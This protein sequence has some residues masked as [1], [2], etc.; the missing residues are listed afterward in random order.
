MNW[1]TCNKLKVEIGH[2]Y[3]TIQTK[4]YW[5]LKDHFEGAFDQLQQTINRY[6]EPQNLSTSI[7]PQSTL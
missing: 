3:F 6:T 5:K 1:L 2:K 4:F 7:S